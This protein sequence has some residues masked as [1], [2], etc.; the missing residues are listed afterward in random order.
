MTLCQLGC[1]ASLRE[2]ILKYDTL[3][4]LHLDWLQMSTSSWLQL[5]AGSRLLLHL[6]KR[7]GVRFTKSF[8]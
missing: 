6:S 3:G 1:H 5:L 8:G 4:S 7:I 2:S